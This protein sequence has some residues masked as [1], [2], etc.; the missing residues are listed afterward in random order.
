MSVF[1]GHGMHLVQEAGFRWNI[2]GCLIAH[3]LSSWSRLWPIVSNSM[4]RSSQVGL[5]HFQVGWPPAKVWNM[6][7]VPMSTGPSYML[8]DL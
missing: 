2:L 5:G 8:L 7:I 1:L 6:Q 4:D 3:L